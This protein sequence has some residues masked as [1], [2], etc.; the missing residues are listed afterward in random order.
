MAHLLNIERLDAG[1]AESA[2]QKLVHIPAFRRVHDERLTVDLRQF[3]PSAHG[4][5]MVERKGKRQMLAHN[6]GRYDLPLIGDGT[7]EA[8]P[9]P[10]VKL[11]SNTPLYT[12][13][14]EDLDIDC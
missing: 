7:D 14:A 11:S 6:A 10:T 13:M 2:G 9:A 1:R 5:Q 4:Q 3:R 12:R 8:L